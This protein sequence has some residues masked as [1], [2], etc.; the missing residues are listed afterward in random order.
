MSD[1]NEFTP[2]QDSTNNYDVRDNP[3]AIS[4]SDKTNAT[5][6]SSTNT[7]KSHQDGGVE[8]SLQSVANEHMINCSN[9]HETGQD[10]PSTARKALLVAMMLWAEF[11]A[12]ASYSVLGPLF[13]KLVN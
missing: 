4:P 1:K 9:E 5:S 7:K 6:T 10:V 3:S 2:S 8:E 13:P 11:S 12:G